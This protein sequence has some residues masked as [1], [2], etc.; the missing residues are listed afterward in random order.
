MVSA[1]DLPRTGP[2]VLE[3]DSGKKGGQRLS[4]PAIHG[5][6]NTGASLH[7]GI[8]P[9]TRGFSKVMINS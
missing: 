5:L 1:T 9:P 8:E 2:D 6:R 7:N 4:L 3:M